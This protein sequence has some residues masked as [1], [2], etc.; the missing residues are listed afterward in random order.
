MGVFDRE[1]AEIIPHAGKDL[2]PLR[3]GLFRKRH[4]ELR[5]GDLM[6]AQAWTDPAHQP[7]GEGAAAIGINALQ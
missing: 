7:A 3:F 1:A 6:A 5:A 2:R 4:G